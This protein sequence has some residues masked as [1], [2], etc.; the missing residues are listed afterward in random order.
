[1]A[2]EMATSES[3]GLGRSRIF[4]PEVIND[5]HVKAE[6]G[7]YRM[8]GGG[9]FK[10]IPHWDELVFLPGTL[11]RFVIEGYREKCTTKT[12]L[13]ARFAKKPLELDIPI[14]ITGM[15]FGALSLEAKM[16]LAKGASMAGTAT[17][18]GEGGMIPPERDFSTKWFYQVIQS[19]YGFNPHHLMLADA[20]EFFIGQGCKVGMGGHLMGQKVTEQVAE[21][22]S[23]PAGIDQ[24]SPARHP[25]WLGPDDLSLKIQEVREATDYQ[26]PIQLKLGASRVYDDVRM[27]AKCGPDVIFLDGAEGGTGAGPHIAT[28]ETGIPLLAAIPEA[29]RALEDVGLSDEIDLVVAGGIRNGGDVAKC[30][31]LG[32][33]AIAIGS[34]A[35]MALGSNKEIEGADYEGTFGVPASQFYHWHTGKDPAGITTQDPELRKRLDV[36]EGAT[37]VYNFLHTLTLE[38]QMLARACGKTNVH[39]LEP[40]D[41]AALTTEASAMARVPLAGTSYIP[42]VTEA[43]T[44]EEIKTLL[45]KHVANDGRGS[46]V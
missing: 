19:R 13:G 6:L 41:L 16:A 42:G 39:S 33:D 36:D 30:I 20:V 5:I 46:D 28:E 15:S 7:R 8:R 25:D 9:I 38:V 1:M 32:A 24:R 22:R 37:R 44:L 14:Y 29:R 27:A 12:V 23:L 34:A 10:K 3:M 11:T 35:L 21:M 45:A 31:A 43:N 26:V 40:E 17:C 18:S 4:T 2:D